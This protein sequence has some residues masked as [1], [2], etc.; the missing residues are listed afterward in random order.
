[1]QGKIREGRWGRG[2]GGTLRHVASMRQSSAI[3]HL[4]LHPALST[5]QPVSRLMDNSPCRVMI[6][7]QHE[8]RLDIQ[9]IQRKTVANTNQRPVCWGHR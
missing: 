6:K 2:G 5:A 1:M 9:R 4:V 7:M 3:C 8:T